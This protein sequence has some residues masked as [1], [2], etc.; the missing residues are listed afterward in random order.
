[1]VHTSA[2]FAALAAAIIV[3]PRSKGAGTLAPHNIPFVLLGTAL[4]WFGWFGFNG[5]SDLA[6]NA[7]GS[8][9]FVNTQISASA[10]FLT[11]IILD[12][13]L[14][15]GRSAAV[16]GA[17]GA[18]VGLVSITAGSG[19][20][21]PWAALPYG[22]ISTLLVYGAIELKRKWEFL[23]ERLDDTLDVFTCHGIGGVVGTI[24]TGFLADP[25]IGGAKGAFYGNGRQVWVQIV[26]AVVALAYSTVA[27]ALILLLLK[28]TPKIGLRTRWQEEELGDVALHRE[29]AYSVEMTSGEAGSAPKDP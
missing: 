19:L 23:R 8:I 6:A 26:G 2:G 14:F 3:G 4:L 28:F 11:W 17:T 7:K 16:G 10:A 1:M 18:I 13:L 12:A 25:A 15:K 5:G 24:L 20:V 9:A 27:T 29:A 22:I 21:R